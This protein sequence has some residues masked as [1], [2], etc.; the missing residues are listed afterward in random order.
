M[1]DTA[2]SSVHQ[3]V[4]LKTEHFGDCVRFYRDMLGL[5]LWWEKPGLVCLRFGGGYLMVEGMGV[6]TSEP[7]S[8]ARNPT[9]LRFHVQDIEAAAA[10][11]GKVGIAVQV[12]HFDWGVIG[13]F[14][15]PD[16]N[17]CELA[18]VWADV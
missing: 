17:P 1:T 14:A 15:D 2:I 12:L 16:G 4:I 3:G 8:V 11:L 6:A 13:T 7:R 9:V 10:A 18:E 5:P